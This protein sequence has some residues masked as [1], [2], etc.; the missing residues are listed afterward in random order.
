MAVVGGCL[1]RLLGSGRGGGLARDKK[2]DTR[3]KNHG[4]IVMKQKNESWNKVKHETRNN[5]TKNNKYTVA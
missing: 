4:T 3:N 5:E 1:L 2:L